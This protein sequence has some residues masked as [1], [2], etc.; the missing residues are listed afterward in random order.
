M[1]SSFKCYLRDFF[2]TQQTN[3]QLILLLADLFSLYLVSFFIV[4]GPTPNNRKKVR[5]LLASILL[6]ALPPA[7]LSGFSMMW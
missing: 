7:L 5:K 1:P 4:L 6:G 3:L 2:F